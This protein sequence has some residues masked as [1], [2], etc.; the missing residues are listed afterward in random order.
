M[1]WLSYRFLTAMCAGEKRTLL[2]VVCE[3]QELAYRLVVNYSK[4]HKWVVTE[5]KLC[6]HNE[7]GEVGVMGEVVL[8]AAQLRML[9]AWAMATGYWKFE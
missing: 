4:M 5:K 2:K 9:L 3:Y 1:L 6:I 7:I 8:L